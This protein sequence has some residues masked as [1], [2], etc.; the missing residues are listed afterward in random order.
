MPGIDIPIKRLFQRRPADWARYV[1]PDCREEW[2]R[3][4]KTEYTPKKESRLDNVLEIDDPSSPYLLHFEPMGYRDEA[5][6]ARMLR[7]RSD[8]WEATLA[9]GRG[10]PSIRQVVMFFYKE[11]DNGLHRLSDRWDTGG[12]EYSYTV[13]RVWEE[14]RQPVITAKLVGLYPL[15]PLMKGDDA[16]ESPEQALKKCIDAVQEIEDESLRQD[17]LAA[18]AILAGGK[19]PPDLVLSMIRREMVME[20]PIFQEW[21]REERAEA[22]ARGKVE[23][24]QDAICKYLRRRFGDASAGLQQEVREMAS[25]EVLD[26]VMEELFAANTLEEAQAIIRDGME[27]FMQ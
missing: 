6:P 2:V 24:K 9:G 10:T 8:I 20:S 18:M 25:L 27:R 4:Y 14:R 15:L 17:L 5:L 26:G 13:I 16:K 22:E 3:P 11:D 21:V 1:Q 19:Y 23:A 12:L 7:Y